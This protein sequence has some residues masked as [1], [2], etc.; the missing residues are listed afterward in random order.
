MWSRVR[1]RAAHASLAVLLGVLHLGLCLA[2]DSPAQYVHSV[3]QI[4]DG[5]P[6]NTITAILQSREGYLWLG[7]FGGVARF[8][9]V[10]FTIFDSANTPGLAG[11]RVLSLHQ[12][13]DGDLWIGTQ[14]NGVSR[15]HQGKA[16]TYTVRDG[17]PDAFVSSIREDRHG[18][19]WINTARGV[20][21]FEHGKMTPYPVHQGRTVAEFC[22][23]ARD[24]A[25]WFRTAESLLRFSPAGE[26]AGLP[27]RD[28]VGFSLHEATDGAIWVETLPALVRYQNGSFLQVI[29]RP[30]SAQQRFALTGRYPADKILAAGNDAAGKVVLLTPRGVLR[31]GDGRL[32]PPQP[33]TL[34]FEA[35]R[36]LIVRSFLVDREN[37]LWIGTNGGGLHRF[38]EAPVTAYGK[39]QGLSD[40]SFTTV[41]QD[42]ERR[43]WL[44]GQFLFWLDRKGFHLFPGVRD[45]RAI[46][47]SPNGDLWFGGYGGLHRWSHGALTHFAPPG[48]LVTAIYN[49]RRG[50]L[51]VGMGTEGEEGG[52]YRFDGGTFSRQRGV[53]DVRF[54]MEDSHGA[55]WIGG[56]EGVTR[57]SDG[58]YLRYTT[59]QGLSNDSVRAIHEDA[60]GTLWIATYGGGLDR[61]KD[62]RFVAMTTNDGLPNNMLSR[63]LE[64]G[65]GNFWISSNR[66]IFRISREELNDFADGRRSS[67]T[68]VSYGVSDGM[69]T[70]ECNGGG[71]PAGWR[72]QDGR[73]WFPTVR[74]VVAID[75]HR[76]NLLPP[77]VIVEQVRAGKV[78]VDPA[79]ETAVPPGNRDLEFQFIAFSFAAPERV[80]LRY[81][82]E[83]FDEDWVDAG[84]RRVAYYTNMAPGPYSF[85][86][87]ASNSDG[88][89]N[90]EGATVRFTLRPHFYE[91]F[92][93]FLLLAVGIVFSGA[94]VYRLRVRH[95]RAREIALERLVAQRTTELQEEVE[96]RKRAEAALLHARNELEDRVRDRTTELARANV[97]LE[98]DIRARQRVEDELRRSEDKFAKAFH[99][100]PASMTISSLDAGRLI[101]V[102]ESFLRLFGYTHDEVIGRTSHQLQ[103]W[104]RSEQRQEVVARLQAHGTV[105]NLETDFR[106]K[107]GVVFDALFSADVIS[108]EGEPCLLI[109]VLDV[110]EQKR[111]QEQLR[112]A[113][114][115]EAL[116]QL[117][118]GVA[119]D[120]NNLLSVIIGYGE[121]ASSAFATEGPEKSYLRQVQSAA[122]R[123]AGLTG[124]LLAF[125]RK[126]V[127]Q[128][129]V[130]NL[131]SVVSSVEKLLRRVIRENI[132]VVITTAAGLGNVRADR[133]Q[134]EQVILNL[135]V[136]ARDAMPSGGTLTIATAN[137]DLDEA[138]ARTHAEARAGN[139]VMLAVS[140]TGI[141]MDATTREHIFEPFFTTKERGKGTGLG[142]ATVYGIV[143]QSG[144]H[145][146]VYSEQGRGTTFKVYLPRVGQPATAQEPAVSVASS[147][148]SE[149]VL[150]VEDEE[151]VRQLVC[152]ALTKQGYEILSAANAEQAL[153]L[154]AN[155]NGLIHILVTDMVMP[156]K[157]GHELAYELLQKRPAMKVLYLSGYTDSGLVDLENNHHAA[158][159]QKPFN[160]GV[161]ARKVRELLDVPES[162]KS[163]S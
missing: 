57:L 110:T 136:N 102:N 56:S 63:I 125:S 8:D 152:D 6:Q 132:R 91:T 24:G 89:W 29:G 130:L 10:R 117:A 87:V 98:S 27:L 22:L 155:R 94:G 5:L 11:D 4:E 134:L 75:P 42:R 108:F 105:R 121:L 15:L 95:L 67:L 13:H 113:Q 120:F 147:G 12:D 45:V 74:G 28:P 25:L 150:V 148:G 18:R 64:D 85:H 159:L 116:G 118:G 33:L 161:L 66:G 71:Q 9:G 7:T 79:G 109:V 43:I 83:P 59:Q 160:L 19:L 48:R 58:A 144:G 62:G 126:Q 30:V 135:C 99:S 123:A 86:V 133:G 88:V 51:W 140:D 49:D 20:A 54:I 61:L 157:G 69:P 158:F 41:F 44:S 37:N 145:I 100:S 104:T 50:S 70:S 21:R 127:L 107:S 82:L 138:Y 115:M 26:V 38:R 119:H 17:L 162:P 78:A 128:S 114:K 2:Q 80:H 101:D 90:Q 77:R 14:D 81:K 93:F 149:T 40:S 122:E 76:L 106:T 97:A 112:Q 36:V 35:E 139:Y 124:Q 46:H 1:S 52:L 103:L 3:W 65:G 142:L 153:E 143:K 23:E 60:E 32:T 34:P 68:P 141:G 156:G 16:T 151:S 72:T 39:E 47:Q 129:L 92:S 131:D 146:W 111:L 84:T 73:L 96:E 137:V 55:L 163:T 31:L 154:S 53:S